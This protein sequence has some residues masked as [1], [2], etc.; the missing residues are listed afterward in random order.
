MSSSQ[1]KFY[2]VLALIVVIGAALIGYVVVNNRKQT[3]FESSVS[4]PPLKEGELVSEEVGVSIGAADAP[5]VIEEYAD[6][7]CPYCG[8]VATLTLPQI[9]EEYVETGKARFIFFDFPV[10]QGETT[11]LGAEAARCAGDQGAFW[12]M[13]K[14][15]M[16]RMREWGEKR[17]P[18][19]MFRGYAD[20]LGLDGKALVDCVKSRKYRETVLASQ[21]RARQLGLSGTPTFIINGRRVGSAMGFDQMS[22]LIEEELA[23]H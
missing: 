18:Q 21:M 14:V 1:S 23:K 10:R 4:L 8:M 5:I 15:L 22:E 7:L 3:A 13:N 12:P 2:G 20:R 9:M 17:D 19:G 16:E 11:Y 6:Y